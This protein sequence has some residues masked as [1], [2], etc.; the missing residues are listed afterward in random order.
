MAAR[1][2]QWWEP[3][4]RDL[5]WRAVRDPWLVLVSE[6]MSQQTG[7][8]RVIPRWHDFVARWPTPAAMAAAPIADVLRA[9]EGLGYPRR[10]RDLHR[11]ATAITMNHG[12][13][14]PH[15]RAALMALPGIGPYTADA[16][17]AFAWDDDVAVVDTN[18]GRVLARWRNRRLTPKELRSDADMLVAEATGFT[19][20]AAMLDFGAVICRKRAPECARCPVAVQC[21]WAQAGADAEDPADGSAAVSRPQK[22]YRGS[23]R[24]LRGRVLRVC[25]RGGATSSEI[26]VAAGCSDRTRLD[27]LLAAL[28][29]EGLIERL[30]N[31][32]GR[33]DTWHLANSSSRADEATSVTP[34]ER[35]NRSR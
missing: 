12:G 24:E 25:A 27:R 16:V 9:W 21:G 18:V 14:V 23:D 17:L 15:D 5:P 22:A 30:T 3:S 20:N 7:L 26:A 35:A 1:V 2:R 34:R 13:E 28:A 33:E 6:V 4:L 19:H 32:H 29:S 11:T 8:G 10:A 31:P